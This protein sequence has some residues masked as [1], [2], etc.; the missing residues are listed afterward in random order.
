MKDMVRTDKNIV[1]FPNLQLMLMINEDD[2]LYLN[3]VTLF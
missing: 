1:I 2:F 3:M